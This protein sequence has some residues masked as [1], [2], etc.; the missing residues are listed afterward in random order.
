MNNQIFP[1]TEAAAPVADPVAGQGSSAE[2]ERVAPTGLFV[3]DELLGQSQYLQKSNLVGSTDIQPSH[4][5]VDPNQWINLS[6][7]VSH[8]SKFMFVETPNPAAAMVWLLSSN[9]SVFI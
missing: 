3:W 2:V 6:D 8:T 5:L 7:Q 1:V 9:P 4:G